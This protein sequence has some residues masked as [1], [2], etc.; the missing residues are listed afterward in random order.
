MSIILIWAGFVVLILALLA[1]DL[2]VFHR[3]EWTP[4]VPEALAWSG[5]WISLALAFTGAVYFLYE[6]NWIGAGLAFPVDVG[7]REASLAYITGFLL[8]KSLSLDNIFVIALVFSH[9]RIPLAHQHR[10]L[11]WGVIGALA[12][13]GAMIAAGATLLARFSWMTYV[14]GGLLLLTAARMLIAHHDSMEPERSPVVRLARRLLPV[15]EELH[16]ARFLVVEGGKRAMTPLLL[17]LLIVETTDLLFAVDSIPAVFAITSDPFVVYTSNVFAILGLRSLYFALAP[18]LSR[19]RFLKSSLVFVLAFVGVKMLLA[20]TEPIP[21]TFS[22]AVVLGILLVG[23]LASVT[24]PES[25]Q[26]EPA[27][28]EVELATLH[29]LTEPGAKRAVVLALAGSVLVLGVFLLTLP[30]PGVLIIAVGLVLVGVQAAWGRHLVRRVVPRRAE[31]DTPSP[32]ET[33][34][35]APPP[36]EGGPDPDNS[37]NSAASSGKDL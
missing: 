27:P 17:V 6:N 18:L 16:G 15:T 33:V 7:G 2:G 4:T 31:A 25:K 30:G 13:R 5:F 24:F 29:I 3:H 1:L 19:F 10:V 20:H 32:T 36:D 8:E 22:L 37:A 11:F 28:V 23:I 26:V 34:R 14:L 35:L 21:V 12:M 9:F